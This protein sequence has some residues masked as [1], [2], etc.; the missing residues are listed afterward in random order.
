MASPITLQDDFSGGMK[1]DFPQDQMPS[2]SVWDVQDML[3][4]RVGTG[5]A[6]GEYRSLE[7][8]G[9][10]EYRTNALTGETDID[11]I[12]YFGGAVTEIWIA[13][14]GSVYSSDLG[15]GTVTD[16]GTIGGAPVQHPV[17]F[18]SGADE[19]L[20][21]FRAS[22]G[23]PQRLPKDLGAIVTMTS[24]DS[25]PSAFYGDVFKQRFWMGNTAS[26]PARVFFSGAGDVTSWDTTNDWV[27]TDAVVDGLASLRNVLLVF[28]PFKTSR[29]RGIAPDL[30]IEEAF[31]ISPF[32]TFSWTRTGPDTMVLAAPEGLIITDG[33]ATKDLT[34]ASGMGSWWREKMQESKDNSGVPSC[35]MGYA[36]G[37]LCIN[38]KY[39]SFNYSFLINIDTGAWFSTT[40]MDFNAIASAPGVG[41]TDFPSDE[42]WA[43]TGGSN[44]RG[45]TVYPNVFTTAQ[46]DGDGT[47]PTP[48]VETP[49]YTGRGPTQ[50]PVKSVYFTYNLG[51]ATEVTG[52]Y[53]TNARQQHTEYTLPSNLEVSS[54]GD[55][56]KRRRVRV[57]KRD[58]MANG[59]ALQ[60]TKTASA[61]NFALSAIEADMKA[62]E[63]SRI[64]YAGG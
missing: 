49:F 1:R 42:I 13:G 24:T 25:A 15:S 57:A 47:E 8:R 37:W 17:E 48:L 44:P 5:T 61:G 64:N 7:T 33:A 20:V 31:P 51:G 52:K 53:K 55:E 32:D 58:S 18:Y 39:A 35:P 41:V 23:T 38:L 22:P 4:N 9:G 54:Q 29:I 62:R 36:D 3:P 2:G 16:E 46:Q 21:M 56:L 12:A 45:L 11:A 40:N 34:K 27:D 59:I 43:G 19:Q 30:I 28:H 60:L 14:D 63:G 10:W 6:D 26:N 50:T